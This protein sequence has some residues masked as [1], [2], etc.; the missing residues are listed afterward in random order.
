MS[1]AVKS[2]HD[3]LKYLTHTTERIAAGD[4]SQHVDFMGDFS[5]AFNSMVRQLKGSFEQ[6]EFH[7]REL[8]KA[9][10]AL[11]G[12]HSVEAR[13]MDMAVTVQRSL[14]PESP[15]VSK[16]W[17]IAYFFKPMAGV[18]GDFYDFYI[19]NNELSGISLFDVS[20]HGI[21]SAIISMIAKWIIYQSFHKNFN[22]NLSHVP[23]NIS[24]DLNAAIGKSDYFLTGVIIKIEGN[25]IKYI[26]AAHPDVYIRKNDKSV[27]PLRKPD[28]EQPVGMLLGMNLTPPGYDEITYKMESGEYILLYTDG[29]SEC[30][31][32]CGEEFGA[33]RVQ[34]ALTEA[35]DG[36]AQETLDFLMDR[37]FQYIGKNSFEDDCTV[38]VIKKL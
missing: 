1:S 15:P 20:G 3:H 18:S 14:M 10:E 26:N 30:C 16:S 6:I 31:H 29:F 25:V 21:S 4:F 19:S 8:E 7:R 2:L 34:K 5:S 13:D 33:L 32:S 38:I 24:R 23:L 28:G 37:V 17:E 35:P 22:E 36:T 12:A 27:F 9:N 11:I